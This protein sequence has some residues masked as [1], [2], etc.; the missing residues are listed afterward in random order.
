MTIP[1]ERWRITHD[2]TDLL[3]Y[4]STTLLLS[5]LG[6]FGLSMHLPLV[7]ALLPACFEF[8]GQIRNETHR[9]VILPRPVVCDEDD[10]WSSVCRSYVDDADDDYAV[11]MLTMMLMMLMMIMMMLMMMMVI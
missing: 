1:A 4:R 3:I 9:R 5:F 10:P 8:Q 7:D 6:Y 11:T 2:T